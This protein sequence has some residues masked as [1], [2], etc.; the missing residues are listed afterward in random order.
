MADDRMDVGQILFFFFLSFEKQNVEDEFDSLKE[1]W[2]CKSLERLLSL[3]LI[4]IKNLNFPQTVR[5]EKIPKTSD[6][7]TL[8]ALILFLSFFWKGKC[9]FGDEFDSSKYRWYYKSLQTVRAEKIPRI[10]GGWI[11][12]PFLSIFLKSRMLSWG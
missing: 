11:S 5:A 8:A 2:C 3:N 1:R 4:R 7:W 9:R 12:I 6:G 10:N